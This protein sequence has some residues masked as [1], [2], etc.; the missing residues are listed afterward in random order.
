MLFF[1]GENWQYLAL[2]FAI[3]PFVSAV[4]FFGSEIPEMETPGRVMG[5]LAQL[6]KKQLWICV[7]AIFL[8]GAAECTMAQWSSGYLEQALGIPKVWGDVLGVAMF[9]VMLGIGRTMYSKIGKNIG[10]VLFF[11]AVGAAVCYFVAAVS[12]FAVVGLIA[13]ALTGFCTSMLWPGNLI[14][15]SDRFDGGGVFIYAMMAAGGDLGASV[16]PQLVGVI[17]DTVIAGS[18]TAALA[19]SLSLSPEQLGMKLGMLFAMLF[20]LGAIFLY[21]HIWNGYR[22][23][24]K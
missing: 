13:C 12:P 5:A 14:V 16:A 9:A 6:K 23:S 10:R 21:K 4:V 17:T 3:V 8:G 24:N 1:G 20:P 7:A 11:G 19:E 18:K 22:K 2:I 15:A